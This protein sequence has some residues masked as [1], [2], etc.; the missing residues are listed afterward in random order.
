MR[1]A[2]LISFDAIAAFLDLLAS[3]RLAP[4]CGWRM[5][6]GFGYRAASLTLDQI[7]RVQHLLRPTSAC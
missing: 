6:T 2:A 1:L 7:A 5:V 3:W 4:A